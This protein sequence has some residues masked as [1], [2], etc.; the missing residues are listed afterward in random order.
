MDSFSYWIFVLREHFIRALAKLNPPFS[1]S[2]SKGALVHLPS[3]VMSD[4]EG[5]RFSWDTH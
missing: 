4:M 5:V 2:D 3:H 1:F